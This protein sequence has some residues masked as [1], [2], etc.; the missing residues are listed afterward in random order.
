M[1]G[2]MAAVLSVAFFFAVAGT[3]FAG[4][5]LG[6]PVY[7]GAVIDRDTS[8][9]LTKGLK[10]KGAAYRTDDPIEKVIDFYKVNKKLKPVDIGEEEAM[11]RRGKVSLTI[12]SP[13]MDM[14]TGQEMT[15]TLISIVGKK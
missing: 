2:K 8:T 4:D 1:I 11:F 15:D 3:A 9:L 14:Q 7:P 12:Q 5:M 6:I 13:W 10:L